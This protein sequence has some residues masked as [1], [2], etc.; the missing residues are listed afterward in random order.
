MIKARM[1]LL[2]RQSLEDSALSAHGEDVLASR[3]SSQSLPV[4]PTD[5]PL[6]STLAVR[7]LPAGPRLALTFKHGQREFGWRDSSLVDVR[8]LVAVRRLAVQH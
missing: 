3:M 2:E 4:L 8:W 5:P 6:Y 1:G 7:V